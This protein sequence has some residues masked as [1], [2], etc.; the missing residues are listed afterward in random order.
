MKPEA[1]RAIRI[2]DELITW[3]A[4]KGIIKSQLSLDKLTSALKVI[5]ENCEHDDSEKY[6]ELNAMA[7][8]VHKLRLALKGCGFTTKGI[9]NLMTDFT[10]EDLDN[11]AQY[12]AKN[13]NALPL[14][15]PLAQDHLKIEK[16]I[17]NELTNQQWN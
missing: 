13:D 11:Y 3:L 4:K 14:N 16:R 12:Y 8:S 2:I 17:K 9:M 1:E 6:A 15:H 10:E 5:A 7:E